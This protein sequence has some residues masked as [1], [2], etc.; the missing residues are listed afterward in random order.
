MNKKNIIDFVSS[1]G[2]MLLGVGLLVGSSFSFQKIKKKYPQITSFPISLVANSPKKEMRE[3]ASFAK[4]EPFVPLQKNTSSYP[5]VL[6]ANSAVVIDDKTGVV[7]FA[8]REEEPRP[9]ASITKLMSALVL[10]E[11]GIDFSTT[12]EVIAKDMGGDQHVA[13]GEIY[14]LD[15]LWH[16]G[17]IASSNAAINAMV[18]KTVSSFS[19]FVNQM[20]KKAAQLRLKSIVFFE[21]TGLDGRNVGS[22][23][24]VAELLR[25]VLLNKKIYKTLQIFDYTSHPLNRN[26]HRVV[27]TDALL[28]GSVDGPFLSADIVGKTGFTPEAGYNFAVRLE[29]GSGHAVRVVVLGSASSESRFTESRDLALWVFKN[30]VWPDQK[31]YFNFVKP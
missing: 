15:D 29:D 24:E 10:I 25:I 14:S 6:T 20:N 1:V 22:A 16:I 23:R 2:V 26:I 21:P 5:N 11:D 31:N 13:A 17:L 28:N 18:R 19:L 4:S 12:T 30:Y 3:T 9:L 27:T 8:K 7:L